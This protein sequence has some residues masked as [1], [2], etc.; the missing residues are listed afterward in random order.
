MRSTVRQ[1]AIEHR[2]AA[3]SPVFLSVI[4]ESDGHAGPPGRESHFR[5]RVVS[6]AFDGQRLVQRH[7]AVNALLTDLM[8]DGGI[9]AMAI[10]AYTPEDWNA[11]EGVGVTSP[12]CEGKR[13]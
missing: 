3:L 5:V 9:H 11:R 12:D 10:E 7:R 8:G 6:A 2:L 1:E 13:S 4:N